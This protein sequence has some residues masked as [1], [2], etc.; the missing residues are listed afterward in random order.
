[1]LVIVAFVPVLMLTFVT[2]QLLGFLLNL[3]TV[4]CFA[5]LHEVARELENPFQ[6]APNDLPA[7]NLH[8]QYNEALMSMFTGYHPDAYWEVK[9]VTIVEEGSHVQLEQVDSIDV[10]AIFAGFQDGGETSPTDQ[11]QGEH[12]SNSNDSMVLL[13]DPTDSSG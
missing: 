7:N 9:E 4:M 8:G 6:N 10:E 2:S 11:A 12:S 1:V 5:G 13:P 3:V